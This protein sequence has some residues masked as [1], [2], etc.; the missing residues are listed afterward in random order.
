MKALVVYNS[1]SGYT[2]TIAR[3]VAAA[4]AEHLSVDVVHARDVSSATLGELDLLVVGGPT[5]G[6]GATP[7]LREM[8][9]GL[10]HGTLAGLA[11][12]TFDTRL[13]WPR[14]L[15]GSAAEEAANSLQ[16]AGGRLV[17]PPESFLV[18]GRVGTPDVA[19]M[20]HARHWAGQVLARLAVPVA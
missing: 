16:E 4:L 8:L 20:E 10:G 17:M 6:H 14:L 1:R 2:E 7:A 15:S 18:E 12:A 5:E 9:A 3:T 13:H 19:A 11:A